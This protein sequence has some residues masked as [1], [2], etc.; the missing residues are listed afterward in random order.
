MISRI[1]RF[2]PGI[3]LAVSTLG[4]VGCEELGDRI[5]TMSLPDC[6]SERDVA[7]WNVSTGLDKDSTGEF[8]ISKWEVSRDYDSFFGIRV[9]YDTSYSPIPYLKVWHDYKSG[10]FAIRF[11]DG[12]QL[13]TPLDASYPVST[14]RL[15]TQDA[16]SLAAQ[17]VRIEHTS[18]TGKW[19][20]YHTVGLP[21]A[22]SATKQDLEIITKKYTDENCAA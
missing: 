7:G 2:V 11:P 3:I 13:V 22:M 16:D 10:N 5:K 20:V 4:I 9:A 12:A 18:H 19:K 6:K 21:D 14:V 15:R 17:P 8:L 1:Q